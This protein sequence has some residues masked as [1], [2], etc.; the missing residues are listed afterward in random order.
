[1]E[2]SRERLGET[3]SGQVPLGAEI[4]STLRLLRPLGTATATRRQIVGGIARPRAVHGRI[5]R[6]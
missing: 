1:M 5:A 4:P 3:I 6:P 2:I